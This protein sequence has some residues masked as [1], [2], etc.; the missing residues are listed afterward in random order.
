GIF[1]LCSR[2]QNNPAADIVDRLS[3]WKERD[4]PDCNAEAHAAAGC[5]PADRAAI[6]ATWLWLQIPQDLHGAYLGG[7][8]YRAAGKERL[9]YVAE[10]CCRPKSGAYTAHHLVD[11]GITFNAEK[12]RYIKRS[13]SAD[14]RY[15]I[16][17]QIHDHPVFGLVLGIAFQG[18][19]LRIVF[20]G[21]TTPRHRSLHGMGFDITAF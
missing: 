13:D 16:A 18:E 15:V 11:R 21:R 10:R 5:S 7:P 17:Q 9:Q 4:R 12:L 1:S 6:D 8:R 2:V 19:F 14:P 20:L 3:A